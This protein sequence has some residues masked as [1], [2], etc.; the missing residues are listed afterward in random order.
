MLR[1]SGASAASIRAG[2]LHWRT[3]Q[4]QG[5]THGAALTFFRLLKSQPSAEPRA[6]VDFDPTPILT[7]NLD[8]V[9]E[10]GEVRIPGF[11]VALRNWASGTWPDHG[12]LVTLYSQARGASRLTLAPTPAERTSP[13]YFELKWSPL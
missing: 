6:R 5:P 7:A 11:A 3:V 13:A 8:A 4:V 12:L 1:R 2:I 9:V 10:K